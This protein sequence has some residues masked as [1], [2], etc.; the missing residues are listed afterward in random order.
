MTEKKK[1][2]KVKGELQKQI[3]NTRERRDAKVEK[4]TEVERGKNRQ[5]ATM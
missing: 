2:Q 4:R 5:E 1:K 3:S